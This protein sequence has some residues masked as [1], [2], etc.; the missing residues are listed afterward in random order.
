MTV[1]LDTLC[2]SVTGH[3]AEVQML[4]AMLIARGYD[5]GNYGIDGDF[6]SATE[7][8]VKNFQT[9]H[10]LTVDGIV[11]ASTWTAVLTK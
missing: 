11:G 5:C 9:A 2:K 6:G 1:E 3:K 4:Q 10:G 7:K 8:A